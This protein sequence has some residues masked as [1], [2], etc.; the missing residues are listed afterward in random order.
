MV[1][2]EKLIFWYPGY[3]PPSIHIVRAE[4]CHLYDAEG[5]RYIDLESGVWCTSIGHGN[6]RIHRVMAEHA[7]L[8]AHTGFSYSNGIV[9]EAAREVLS[10]HGFDGGKCVFLCSGS[11][12]VE[13]GVRAAQTMMELPLLRTMEDSYFGAYGSA[14]LKRTDEWFSFDWMNCTECKSGDA[15][16]DRCEHWAGI[17]FD[18]I[19][20]FLAKVQP[21]YCS[22][23]WR[24]F[25]PAR[26][27]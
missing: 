8:I 20:G 2:E 25:R 3:G 15:C 27:G 11:E 13:F 19:G 14:N 1:G 10:L 22:M 23:V 16:S 17:P 18:D 6:P 12:A 9:P 26:N 5:K 21:R 7:A 24:R 4:N